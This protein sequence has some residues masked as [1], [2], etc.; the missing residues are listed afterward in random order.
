MPT[1]LVVEGGGM[2]TVFTAGVLDTF[3]EHNYDPFD[4]FIGSSAGSLNLA[5]FIAGQKKYSVRVIEKLAN[6]T[7]FVN[8]SRFL[9]GG[10]AVE[11]G[12]L[13]EMISVHAPMDIRNAQRRLRSRP[14]VITSCDKACGKAQYQ[15]TTPQ[16]WRQH[17]VASCALPIV[18]RPGIKLND[19]VHID[20]GLVDPI[21]VHKA[22]ALGADKLVIIRTRTK[23]WVEKLSL[24]ERLLS[25]WVRNDAVMIKLLDEYS[26][27]YNRSCE[28]IRNPPDGVKILEIAP[29]KELQTPTLTREVG[30]L[31]KDYHA[32]ISAA[33]LFLQDRQRG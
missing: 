10:N 17:I 9:K 13:A 14:F 22:V 12:E 4:L 28:F 16:R 7:T 32:G 8:W 11:I 6:S 24:L 3:L 33:K 30:T 5:A 21:P 2:R 26:A 1:A 20:G 19:T 27:T 15:L 23:Q 31:N 29:D 18:Y 25:I